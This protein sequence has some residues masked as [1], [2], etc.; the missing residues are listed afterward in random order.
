[1]NLVLNAIQAM[2]SGGVLT[3]R[4]RR[5]GDTGVIEFSDTGV[6]MSEEVLSQVTEPFFTTRRDGT[7]LGLSISRQLTELN[8]GRLEMYSAIGQGTTVVLRLPLAEGGER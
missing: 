1:M 6:G 5:D 4:A 2:P 7:G 8:G 3:I